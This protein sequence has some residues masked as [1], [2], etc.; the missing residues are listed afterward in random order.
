MEQNK[1]D[2]SFLTFAIAVGTVCVGY[3]AYQILKE[4]MNRPKYIEVPYPAE[5]QDVQQEQHEQEYQKASH[6]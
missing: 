5:E 4:R 3:Y 6:K 2:Y 1:H